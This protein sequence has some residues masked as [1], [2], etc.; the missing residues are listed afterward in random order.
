METALVVGPASAR[1]NPGRIS[2]ADFLPSP[3]LPGSMLEKIPLGL[4]ALAPTSSPARLAIRPVLDAP[5]DSECALREG[6]PIGS[7]K[8]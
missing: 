3:T 5:P 1:G 8:N 4:P 6:P 2:E 7:A